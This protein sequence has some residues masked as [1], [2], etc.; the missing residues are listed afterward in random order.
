V[1]IAPRA[2]A[3]SETRHQGW[4]APINFTDLILG[5]SRPVQVATALYF[6]WSPIVFVC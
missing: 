4:G 3:A 5:S 2:A 6:V 1:K